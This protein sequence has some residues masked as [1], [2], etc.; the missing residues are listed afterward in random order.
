MRAP[1]VASAVTFLALASAACDGSS[2]PDAQSRTEAPSAAAPVRIAFAATTE[3]AR[4]GGAGSF[5]LEDTHDLVLHADLANDAH[6]GETLLVRGTAP[7]GL[8]V[9]S[10]PRVQKGRALDVAIHMLG[11]P[12]AQKHL[13]GQYT[14]RVTAPDGTV[15]AEGAP[16]FTSRYGGSLASSLR[17]PTGGAR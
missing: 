15:V 5:V 17:A 12:A 4:K 7:N 13:V 8:L 9:W 10:H 11:S 2:R 16:Q 3:D 6:E 1:L 14:F